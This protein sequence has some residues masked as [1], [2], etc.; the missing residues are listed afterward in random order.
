MEFHLFSKFSDR[1][2]AVKALFSPLL[3][4]V[5]NQKRS[6]GKLSHQNGS[7]LISADGLARSE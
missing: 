2:D 7:G 3:E 4:I 5:C 6:L 1:A